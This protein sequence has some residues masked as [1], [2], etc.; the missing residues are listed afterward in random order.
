MTDIALMLGD[1]VQGTRFAI[2]QIDVGI[3]PC[4]R[5]TKSHVPLII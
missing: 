3:I 2:I 4:V 1:Q 5:F